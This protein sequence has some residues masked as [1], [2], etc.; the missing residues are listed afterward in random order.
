MVLTKVKYIIGLTV[1]VLGLATVA[2]AQDSLRINNRKNIG[3]GAHHGPG[4]VDKNGDGINDNAP[5]DDGDGIPNSLDPDYTGP[6]S[7]R[8]GRGF[9]DENGDGINDNMQDFDGDG[10]PNGRDPDYNRSDNHMKG[11]RRNS[12]LMRRNRMTG[13]RGRGD[14]NSHMSGNRGSGRR[15]RH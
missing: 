13:H 4:F 6:K 5:D 9:V 15:G 2:N 11:N 1:F 7:H 12:H 10:I 8:N 3:K 14:D